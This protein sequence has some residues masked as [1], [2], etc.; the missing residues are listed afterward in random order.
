MD[1]DTWIFFLG[2]PGTLILRISVSQVARIIDVSHQHL[3]DLRN[4]KVGKDK[5]ESTSEHNVIKLREKYEHGAG[6]LTAW[7]L[8]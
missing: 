4:F 1:E 3:A 6:E 5:S 2:Y 7:Q 8:S